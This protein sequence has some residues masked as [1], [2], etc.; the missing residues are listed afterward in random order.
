M[1]YT[2]SCLSKTIKLAQDA[3][4]HVPAYKKFLQMRNFDFDCITEK[5]FFNLPCMDKNNYLRKF[6]LI[7]LCPDSRLPPMISSSS[8][9]SGKSFYWP[10]GDAEEREGGKTHEKIF[11]DI[12]KIEKKT[13]T[14]V[15]VCFS[16][17]TW[18]AGTFTAAACR[19]LAGKGYSLSVITPG[20]DKNDTV[21]IL[22]NFAPLFEKIIIA[23]YP[24]FVLDILIWAKEK[25]IKLNH[26]P[27]NLLLAGENFSEKWRD[28]IHSLAGID[29]CFAGSIN[30]YGS[31]DAGILG[32]ETPLTT[33][34]R[35]KAS[36]NKNL[37][38]AIWNDLTYQ[39][40][41]VQYY[42]QQKYFEEIDGYLVFTTSAGIPLIRYK[43]GDR[44]KIFTFK[45]MWSLLNKHQLAQEAEA[46]NLKKWKLPFAALLGRDDVAATFYALNIYPE[47]IKAG[48]DDS[49]VADYVTGKFIIKVKSTPDDLSQ[50]LHIDVQLKKGVKN[51]K[52]LKQLISN[53]IFEYLLSQNTEYRKLYNSIGGKTKPIVTMRDFSQALFNQPSAKFKWV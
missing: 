27:L 25:G 22:Q 53:S 13:P 45:Q 15:I 44:G 21:D 5:K 7:E 2:R 42:P 36:L 35:K 10:R 39:S 46:L 50:K 33:F 38:R 14:L 23:G 6:P 32:H 34:I 47:N 18:V 12:F 37:N 48:L 41:L 4:I 9:S 40:T 17:G 30:I 26:L 1:T 11:C 43:I 28:K 19:Y 49:R 51:T 16:M 29:N 24:P 3:L 52:H 20:I 8:G 31:A